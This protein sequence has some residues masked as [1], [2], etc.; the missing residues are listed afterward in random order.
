MTQLNF[1]NIEYYDLSYSPEF[2]QSSTYD[3]I[4]TPPHERGEFLKAIK[5]LGTYEL[6]W[7]GN[8]SLPPNPKALQTTELFIKL[9]P[10]QRRFPT[11]IYP[12]SDESVV[13]EWE[14][15]PGENKRIITFD[16]YF[17]GAVEINQNGE[18]IDLGNFDLPP[19]STI[20]SVGI[21]NLAPRT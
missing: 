1:D 11:C 17:V 13:L 4:L 6:D 18:V 2:E 10:W 8:G 14:G 20:L 3:K 5:I 9:L 12:G 21:Q 16:P 7:D 15:M 19:D